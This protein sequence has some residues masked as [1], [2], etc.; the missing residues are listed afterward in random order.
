MKIK[1]TEKIYNSGR[2]V[3]FSVRKICQLAIR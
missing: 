1:A 3:S 2:L